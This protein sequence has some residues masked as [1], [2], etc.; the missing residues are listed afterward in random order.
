MTSDGP[1]THLS[2]SEPAPS[3][4]PGRTTA[5]DPGTSLLRTWRI[6][7]RNEKAAYDASR[8]DR[9]AD[10]YAV[11]RVHAALADELQDT[12]VAESGAD[13]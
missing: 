11:Y 10:A 9:S 1:Q 3:A 2:F 4:V 6:A 13:Q 8:Q 12:L 5:A 7:A